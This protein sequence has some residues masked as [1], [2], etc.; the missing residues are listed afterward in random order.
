[1]AGTFSVRWTLV[2]SHAP[3]PWHHCPTCATAR[4][5][6]SSGKIRLNANGRRLDAWLIYRCAACDQTWNRAL[7]ERRA[8]Q[9]IAPADLDAL[10]QSAPACVEPFEHDVAALR[11]QAVRVD[12]CDDAAVIKPVRPNGVVRYAHVELTLA[13][14]HA[15]GCRLDRVL[16]REL[17]VSRTQL[18]ALDK[19]CALTV[20]GGGRKALHRSIGQE[21]IIHLKSEA[22]SG[23]DRA[24]FAT[25]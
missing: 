15:T 8:V 14:R 7:F 4:A 23:L 22:M 13:V 3:M 2:P 24:L 17:G 21:I 18:Q 10:Q 25:E 1:M 11:R 5:F 19:S 20:K 6:R 9:R 12:L 16:A